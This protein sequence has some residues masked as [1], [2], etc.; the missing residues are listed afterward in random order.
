M[1]SDLPFIPFIP[2]PFYPGF[3]PSEKYESQLGWVFPIYGNIKFMFQTTTRFYPFSQLFR[4]VNSIH[5]A[6]DRAAL[7]IRGQGMDP[8]TE[9]ACAWRWV[10]EMGGLTMV[11]TRLLLTIINHI[12]T[13]NINKWIFGKSI[14]CIP[15]IPFYSIYCL[16][17]MTSMTS[18]SEIRIF[19]I[20]CSPIPWWPANQRRLADHAGRSSGFNPFQGNCHGVMAN[21][22]ADSSVKIDGY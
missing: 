17:S 15:F 3:N 7:L 4:Y 16:T 18:N 14:P 11:L 13:I 21:S 20:S 2:G 9:G 10:D 5:L 12:V 1:H 6:I 19:L 22:A 8:W